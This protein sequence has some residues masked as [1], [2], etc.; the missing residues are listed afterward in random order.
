MCYNILYKIQ[1][2]L[3]LTLDKK[4]QKMIQ[5]KVSKTKLIVTGKIW[6]GSDVIDVPVQSETWPNLCTTWDD[7]LI[8]VT[9]YQTETQSIEELLA[10]LCVDQVFDSYILQASQLD[11]WD[12]SNVLVS[13][14]WF[15]GTTLITV[16]CPLFAVSWYDLVQEISKVNKA[17]VDQGKPS[18]QYGQINQLFKMFLNQIY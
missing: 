8:E 5:T 15:T 13:S 16:P 18:T 7:L 2:N 9:S 11:D 10:S 1:D 12:K 3:C 17:R 14:Q 6:N 4:G